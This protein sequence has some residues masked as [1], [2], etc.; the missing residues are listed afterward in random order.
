MSSYWKISRVSEKFLLLSSLELLVKN[1][2]QNFVYQSVVGRLGRLR[3][4]WKTIK[5]I[6]LIL[7]FELVNVDAHEYFVFY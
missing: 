6:I 5:T 3:L 2:S 7:G 4:R 1:F